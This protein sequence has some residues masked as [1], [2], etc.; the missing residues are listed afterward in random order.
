MSFWRYF[1][2]LRMKDEGRRMRGEGVFATETLSFEFVEMKPESPI[3]TKSYAFALSI[4]KLCRQLKSN[5]E[6]I[7]ANQILKSG[8]SIGANVE[9]AIG[10]QSSKDFFMKITIAYKEARETKYWLRLLN[11][12]DLISED[13]ASTLKDDVEELL[14]LLGSMQR[15]VRKRL[16]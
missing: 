2:A 8:T 16:P 12:T 6:F 3:Q 9:E 4:V 7:L 13:T 11:D 10:G 15:T 14:K 1:R 5:N